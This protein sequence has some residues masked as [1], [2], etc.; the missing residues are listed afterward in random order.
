M[1][2]HAVFFL[3]IAATPCSAADDVPKGEKV[4][5][6]VYARPYFEKNNSG[7]TGDASFLAVGDQKKFDAIFGVG[8]VMGK[9]P[10][11]L[12]KDAFDKQMVLSVIKRGNALYTYKVES[13]T[14]ADGVISI[15][16]TAAG[17]DAGGTATYN[18]VLL[19]AVPKGK[20]KSAAFIENGKKAGSAKIEK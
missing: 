3:A 16:Y 8:F 9:R 7:L 5:F 11:M 15:V 20:F 10:E 18:S 19:V 17:K 6:K 2:I 12:A 14:A 4:E 13:V 1:R